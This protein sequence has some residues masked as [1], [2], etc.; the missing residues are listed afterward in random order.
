M[1]IDAIIPSGG[2]GSRFSKIE[3]KQY[4]KI[5]GKEILYYTLKNLKETYNFNK[6][7]IGGLDDDRNV[8]KKILESLN[9]KNYVISKAGKL[10]QETVFNCLLESLTDIV[11]IHDAVRPIITPK[12]VKNVITSIENYDGAICGIQLRDALKEIG[13]DN[14]V[15]LSLDRN[16]YVLIHTPQVFK[17]KTLMTALDV[18]EK[19]NK[20]I[21]DESEALEYIGG[22]VIFVKSM[23]YNIKIT[24]K[25]DI[26][27]VKF[28]MKTFL[29]KKNS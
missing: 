21:Y 7:I 8:I 1:K 27:F 28:L 14:I 16:Q 10:R 26:P 5:N 15:K 6:F 2:V 4:Y 22:K 29:S 24:Y 25:E 23:F 18:I 9:I 11:L 20:I 19:K 3:K 13:E 12:I 17:R